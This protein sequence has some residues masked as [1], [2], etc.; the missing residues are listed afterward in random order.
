MLGPLNKVRVLDFTHLLPGELCSTILADLGCLIT[1]IEALKP[2]LAQNLPPIVKGESLYYWSVHRKKRRLSLDLKNPQALEVVQK[3]VAG[4]DIVLENF[5]PGVMTRL[6]I[7]YKQLRRINN[8]LIFCSISGYGQDSSWSQRPGHDLNFVAE[9]GILNLNR[10][11][12]GPPVIPGV[13]ISDFLAAVYAALAV[14][15]ALTA[16]DRTGKGKHVDISMFECAL[17]TMNILSTAMLYTGEHP[18]SGYPMQQAEMPNYNVYECADGRY[19]AVAS[20]EPQFWQAFCKVI[21]RPDLT[22]TFKGGP[23]PKLKGEL[24]QIIRKKSLAE[25]L[26]LFEPSNCCVS[27]V[28]TLNEALTFLPA[29]ERGVITTLIHPVLGQIPQLTT[30]VAERSGG[31]DR[32]AEKGKASSAAQLGNR[33]EESLA[34][35]KSLGY[36]RRKIESLVRDKV[37]SLG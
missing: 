25:W 19:L 21:G 27:P 26:N 14:S 35:L 23:D 4:S 29:R 31:S 32:P 28:H 1:R 5:R 34:I 9:A 13:L 10:M 16:R 33:S 12:D 7:G 8:R 15:S 17:S 24:A 22:D 18:E 3:L 11:P 20:L 37:L 36:S 6:G 2:G 30:P